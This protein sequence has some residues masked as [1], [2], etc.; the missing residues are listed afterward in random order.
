MAVVRADLDEDV[1]QVV[2]VY[3]PVLEVYD[4]EILELFV[5]NVLVFTV[6]GEDVGDVAWNMGEGL[7]VH[8]GDDIL[9]LG[10]QHNYF[11]VVVPSGSVDES[12]S[13]KRTRNADVPNGIDP[14]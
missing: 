13:T 2:E 14:H 9:L 7:V 1:A 4:D 3:D 5:E 12:K 8:K 11:F 10:S 6:Q